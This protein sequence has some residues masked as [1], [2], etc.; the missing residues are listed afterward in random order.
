MEDS[1]PH[2]KEI[3]GAS[4]AA[5]PFDGSPSVWELVALSHKLLS[6]FFTF[7][8]LNRTIFSSFLFIS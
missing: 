8:F 4:S 7:N 1:V 5:K 2:F 6:Y 3:P